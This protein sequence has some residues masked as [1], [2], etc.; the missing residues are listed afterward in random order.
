MA[1]MDVFSGNAFSMLE[2][3]RGLEDI[4]YKPG[5][6]RSLGLFTF[7]GIRT[8]QF[9]IE[10]RAGVLSLIPFSERGAPGTQGKGDARTI[11]D[12]RTCHLKKEDT[13][14]ASE[15]AGIRAF[16]SETELMQ[17]QGEVARRALKLRNDAELTFEYH[18]LNALQGKV[19]D[20][21][22]TTLIYDWYQEF[23]ITAA[24]E[25]DFDL[26]NATPAKGALRKKCMAVIESIE[27]DVGGLVPGS[28]V[29]EAVCGSAFFRDLTNHPDVIE[30]YLY[31]AK[32]NELA[33]RPMDVFDWGGIRWR[34]Y[35]GGS[36]VG[37]NTDKCHL[38]PMGIDGLFEQYGSPPDTF[39]LVNTPGLETYY[40]VIP[41]T[42]RNE[43]VTIEMEANPMFVCTRPKV[44]RQGKRT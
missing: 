44:L 5:L 7:R 13:I 8:R 17:V 32:A 31:A 16:G 9:A 28:V 20:T 4:P 43:F 24:A 29:I 33:G 21:D 30:T 14:W 35:R 3:T 22:G 11:R 27:D 6:I 36:G 25:I 40:R 19:L 1:T 12:F 23:G 38:Y 42:K 26:D 10:S 2:L 34:R 18:M 39:D 15:V 41:D 37:V